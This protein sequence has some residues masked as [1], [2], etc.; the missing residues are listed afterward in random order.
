MPKRKQG[1]TK[2]KQKKNK[3]ALIENHN[4]ISILA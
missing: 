3:K 2:K 4:E 1:A